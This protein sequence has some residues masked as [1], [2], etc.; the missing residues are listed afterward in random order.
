MLSTRDLK[1][2]RG[3][4]TAGGILSNLGGDLGVASSAR[5]LG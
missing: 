3:I 4:F 5:A 1:L 2:C